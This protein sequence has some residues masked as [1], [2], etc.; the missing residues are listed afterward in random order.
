MKKDTMK[1]LFESLE[2]DFD[3]HETP[4]GHQSRFLERLQVVDKPKS[5]IRNWVYPLTIAASIAALVVFGFLF[6]NEPTMQASLASVSPE[7]EQTESFF[8]STINEELR[9]LKSFETPE[10]EA[11]V[12]D[13]ISQISILET[14]Y[15]ALKT[16][17]V[18]SGNDQ[19]VIHAMINN[20][21]SRIDLLEQV[22]ETI[23]Q[24]KTLKANRDETT[25]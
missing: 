22:I 9:T 19:R 23:E 25:I 11:L 16:D 21:Q 8:V 10:T 24:I 7:M 2:G 3:I 1:T 17:L 13:A 20:F 14:Q 12:K 6:Q 15:E 4:T 18:N 5:K